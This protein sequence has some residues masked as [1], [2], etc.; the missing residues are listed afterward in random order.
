MLDVFFP[1][2]ERCGWDPE[3]PGFLSEA[4]LGTVDLVP[5]NLPA[6]KYDRYRVLVALGY[7]RMTEEIRNSL[8]S[9]VEK[10]GVLVC[11][12][13]LFLDESE[14][15]CPSA[16]SEA[17]AGCTWEATGEQPIH[18]LNPASRVEAINGVALAD[19]C[20]ER[21]D[22]WLHP[23]R[24]TSGHAVG[25]FDQAPWMIEN[26]IGQGRVLFLT[27]LNGVGSD[28]T[29]RGQEPFL[30]PNLLYYFLHSV[31]D[32]I[33]DGIA[34]APWTGLERIYN[35]RTDGTGLLLVAN[36][37]DMPYRRDLTMKNPR[38]YR[39][40]RVLAKGTWEDWQEG[41]GVELAEKG[42]IL[43]WSFEMTPKSFVVFEMK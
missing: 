30:F 6:G 16:L 28:S 35:E 15:Q 10:G 22:V 32:E 18:L 4:P 1:G 8:R 24:L 21:N 38:G 3:Y 2:F 27:G 34:I 9:W 19:D 14:K 12:D 42:E 43:K 26:R 40:A 13:S 20:E 25:W 29:R 5:D 11:G 36:H 37:G 39:S 31:S 17:L 7:H 23:V 41:G 33:G